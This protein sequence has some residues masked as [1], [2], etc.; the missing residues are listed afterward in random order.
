MHHRLKLKDPKMNNQLG[1]EIH[2]VSLI[3]HHL[4]VV[5][6]FLRTIVFLQP[7]F[8]LQPVGN[9]TATFD[10]YS[11]VI[12]ISTAIKISFYSH[13]CRSQNH[14]AVETDFDFYSQ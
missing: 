1:C 7:I 4:S 9:S 11:H 6:L 8:F 13:G 12:L 3:T 14:V 10:F 2:W 5:L